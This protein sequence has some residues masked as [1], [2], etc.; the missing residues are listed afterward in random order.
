MKIMEALRVADHRLQGHNYGS[1]IQ[2]GKDLLNAAV[3]L[4]GF[5]FSLEDDIPNNAFADGSW[6]RFQ[7]PKD[8]PLPVESQE[9][10]LP[11][12]EEVPFSVGD[13]NAIFK[14]A[15]ALARAAKTDAE[16][17]EIAKEYDVGEYSDRADLV[18]KLLAKAGYEAP[19]GDD[20]LPDE[21]DEIPD[22]ED[23]GISEDK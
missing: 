17:A 18:D 3:C 12:G 23:D 21:D 16:L 15:V 20:F 19:E 1:E 13:R 9:L 5:G 8:S 7:P 6:R 22:A 11:P 10:E 4:L 14:N 2:E